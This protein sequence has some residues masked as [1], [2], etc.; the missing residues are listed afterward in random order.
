MPVDNHHSPQKSE[1]SVHFCATCQWIRHQSPGVFVC[2]RLGWETKP[3]YV[4]SC[5]NPRPRFQPKNAK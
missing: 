2:S 3:K 5:W 1:R 4:F